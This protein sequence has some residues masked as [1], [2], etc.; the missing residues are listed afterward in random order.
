MI[1]QG[2]I[3]SESS[4]YSRQVADLQPPKIHI[5]NSNRLSHFEENMEGDAK[6]ALPRRDL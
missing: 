4:N 1:Q 5:V 6:V 3:W 2:R